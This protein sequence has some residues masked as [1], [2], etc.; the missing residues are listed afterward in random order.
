VTFTWHLVGTGELQAAGD[1]AVY[2]APVSVADASIE[3]VAQ[4][5]ERTA[6][7]SVPVQ[8]REDVASPGRAAGIPDPTPVDAPSEPW[9]SRIRGKTWEYNE[10]HRDY[11]AVAEDEP[12]RVRYL[13]HLFAKEV[14]LRNF[15]APAEEELLERMIEVLTH[16]GDGRAR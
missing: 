12:R 16:L 15:G 2:R 10:G 13:I 5:G 11:R 8:V 6:S 14:V 9:R 7:V 3:V 1:R 4:H